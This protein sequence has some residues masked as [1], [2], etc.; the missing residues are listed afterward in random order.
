MDSTFKFELR[1]AF[2]IQPPALKKIFGLLVDRIGETEISAE[3]FDDV[4]R[5]FD[6]IEALLKYENTRAKRIL[7]LSLQ[8]RSIDWKKTASIHFTDRWYFGGTRLEIKARDDVLSHLRTD[9]L[10]IVAGQRPWYFFI[11]KIDVFFFSFLLF[12]FTWLV[13]YIGVAIYGPEKSADTISPKNQAILTLVAYGGMGLYIGCTYV[14]YKSQKFVFPHGTFAIGQETSR[15]ETMEKWRWSLL[16]GFVASL[17]A[18][19]AIIWL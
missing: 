13:C 9:I 4:T 16:M 8:A 7:N 6:N 10:D 1:D 14:I 18:S 5:K 3:C 19:I 15:Y 12:V 11:N 2:I 17:L